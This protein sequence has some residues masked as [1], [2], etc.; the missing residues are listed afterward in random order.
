MVQDIERGGH[1]AINFLLLNTNGGMVKLE[2]VVP[3][4]I[5]GKKYTAFFDD[6]TRVHFGGAGCM[7][8]IK[9]WKRDGP[10]VA[11]AKRKAYITRHRVNEDWLDPKA[12]GTLSR[13]ILWEYPTL[14]QAIATY[15]DTV[16]KWKR[17][18]SKRYQL[19]FTL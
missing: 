3:S 13:I 6:G 8:F 2:K 4:K 14:Q 7:D 17:T 1:D 18:P 9:Y 5:R 16:K 12:A 19:N 15:D 11:M 10:H